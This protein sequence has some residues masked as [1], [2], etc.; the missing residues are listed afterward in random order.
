MK[1]RKKLLE[2]ATGMKDSEERP[3]EDPLNQRWHISRPPKKIE[4][5]NAG[6]REEKE[7]KLRTRLVTSQ[8]NRDAT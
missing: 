7:S 3:A 1:A 2:R 4:R 5:K 6:N 8:Q